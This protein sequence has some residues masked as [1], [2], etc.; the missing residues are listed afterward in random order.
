[1][2]QHFGGVANDKPGIVAKSCR[3][4]AK[5]H[6]ALRFPAQE[7]DF[8]RWYMFGAYYRRRA[9]IFLELLIRDQSALAEMLSHG[10]A[11]IGGGMLDVWPIYV[12]SSKC[13]VGLDRFAS[14]FR[15]ADDQPSNYIH[16]I[17]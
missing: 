9:V 10:R 13:K 2:G 4:V 17:S 6:P 15:V 1:M 3:Y 7:L 8:F 14:I 5:L 16:L 12:A 11:R